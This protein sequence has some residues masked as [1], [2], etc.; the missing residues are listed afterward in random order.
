MSVCNRLKNIEAAKEA[1]IIGIQ[2]KNADSLQQDL[3]LLGIKFQNSNTDIQ[4]HE[5]WT[6][7]HWWYIYLFANKLNVHTFLNI[8]SFAHINI[9]RNWSS[10]IGVSTFSSVD[11]I[12]ISQSIQV[13][14]FFPNYENEISW[15]CMFVSHL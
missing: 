8:L 7:P 11:E 4:E 5:L 14:I 2:F 9:W 3:S 1:G 10:Q 13:N 6:R 12:Y 15:L